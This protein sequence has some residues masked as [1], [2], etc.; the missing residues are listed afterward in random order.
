MSLAARIIE[1]LGGLTLAGGDHD[2]ATLRGVWAGSGVSLGARFR[3]PLGDSALTVGRGAGKSALVSGIAAAVV[4]PS[5]P[6]HG[7]RREV[8]CVA[9]SFD[10]S[11]VIFEDV[12][13]FLSVR[14]DLE[15]RSTMAEARFR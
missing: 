14:F 1:Y 15:D 11:R 13:A 5:G 8:V 3:E 4:D 7:N 9:S 2:G 10:Q 6:L 12:L